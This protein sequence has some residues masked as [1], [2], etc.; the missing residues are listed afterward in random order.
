MIESLDQLEV[1]INERL[2]DLHLLMM[3][4]EQLGQLIRDEEK[5]RSIVRSFRVVKAA[6]KQ[7]IANEQRHLRVVE[8]C[9]RSPSRA[10]IV[11]Q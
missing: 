8:K 9:G 3:D 2:D 11:Y 7:R 5:R 4:S 6:E 10:E 1:S